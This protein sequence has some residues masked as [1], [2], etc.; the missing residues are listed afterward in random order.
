MTVFLQLLLARDGLTH[1]WVTGIHPHGAC[2]GLQSQEGPWE[3]P[4]CLLHRPRVRSHCHSH[5]LGAVPLSCQPWFPSPEME[6][7]ETAPGRPRAL[8]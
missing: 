7:L 3:E 1:M 2:Q 4:G 6:V 8:S 5:H